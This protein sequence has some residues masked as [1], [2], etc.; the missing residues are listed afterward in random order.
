MAPDE[1]DGPWPDWEGSGF[2]REFGVDENLPLQEP[3]IELGMGRFGDVD[4]VR[5]GGFGLARKRIRVGPRL[6]EYLRDGSHETRIMHKLRHEHIVRFAG[7]YVQGNTLGILVWP[8]AACNLGQLLRAGVSQ[9]PDPTDTESCRVWDLLQL[10]SDQ[11]QE[12]WPDGALRAG[13]QRGRIMLRRMFGCI[14]AGL[15]YLHEQGIRHKDIKPDNILVTHNS[16]YLSDFGVSLDVSKL[17]QD[18]GFSMTQGP[19]AGTARYFS[20]EAARFLPRGRKSDI[21]S[22]GCFFFEMLA[23]LSEM[24]LNAINLRFTG[25]EE[26]VTGMRYYEHINDIPKLLSEI[27]KRPGSGIIPRDLRATLLEMLQEDPGSRPSA[28]MVVQSLATYKSKLAIVHCQKCAKPAV[29]F[30]NHPRSLPEYRDFDLVVYH[31]PRYWWLVF[32]V[33][34]LSCP[35][36]WLILECLVSL[37]SFST[38]IA[39]S[40]YAYLAIDL[41]VLGLTE[42]ALHTLHITPAV[43]CSIGKY[44]SIQAMSLSLSIRDYYITQIG[45]LSSPLSRHIISPFWHALYSALNIPPDGA[46]ARPNTPSPSPLK[47]TPVTIV[48]VVSALEVVLCT[49]DPSPETQESGAQFQYP[50]IFYTVLFILVG[51]ILFFGLPFLLLRRRANNSFNKIYSTTKTLADIVILFPVEVMLVVLIPLIIFLAFL[52]VIPITHWALD[53]WAFLSIW[54][55]LFILYY[56]AF[57]YR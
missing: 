26:P 1:Q 54:T 25:E 14:A 13:P 56:L 49:L 42:R 24:P 27:Q 29:L 18:Q 11:F 44:C 5:C 40:W 47:S 35:R 2:P 37:I 15:E 36:E 53:A 32:A 46:L 4:L 12:F 51:L 9:R 45:S 48:T 31:L 21:F 52:L 50:F 23:V 30:A 43:T 10:D 34:F 22:L 6:Q 16:V 19:T 20:P 8:V 55:I 33:H 3:G 7:S 28:D 17:I 39:S 57:I 38:P 41:A